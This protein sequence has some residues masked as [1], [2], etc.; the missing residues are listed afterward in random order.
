[1][2][3]KEE[4]GVSK[5]KMTVKELKELAIS[6]KIAEVDEIMAMKKPELLESIGAW[7]VETIAKRDAGNPKGVKTLGSAPFTGSTTPEYIEGKKVASTEEVELNGKL[8]NKV[9]TEDGVT[10]MVIK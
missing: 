1:M 8:Y 2:T 10:F 4:I 9:I 5:E 3:K 6:L 7:E